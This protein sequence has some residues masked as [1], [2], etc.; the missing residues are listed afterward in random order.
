MF[1]EHQLCWAHLI[2]KA[3]KLMLQNPAE[4]EYADFWNSLCLIYH[5]A[6]VHS[7]EVAVSVAGDRLNTVEGRR[8]V[9]GKL[10]SR[11]TELCSRRE[12]KIITAKAAAKATP[13]LEATA[14]DV[15]TFIKLQRELAEQLECL[16]VFVE[17]PDVES[18]N[19]R[20]ERNAR[21][22]AESRKCAREACL[23]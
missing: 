15:A 6:K 12:E 3:I 17:H 13:P 5:D 19:N 11:I 4:A 18:T 23:F 2:R 9:I 21:H 16:F 14:A 7:K 22:E 10:Q 20:S 1:S 8:E